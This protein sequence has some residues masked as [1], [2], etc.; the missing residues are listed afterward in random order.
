[1]FRVLRTGAPWRDL[2]PDYGDGCAVPRRFR[3]WRKKGVWYQLLEAVID[4]PDLEGLMIET[5][6][7]KLHQ[8]GAG[9]VDGNQALDRTKGDPTPNC[10]GR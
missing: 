9:A 3:R 10:I 5:R 4:E 7:I 6:H 1:M 2:P 8:H